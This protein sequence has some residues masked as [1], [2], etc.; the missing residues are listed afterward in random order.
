MRFNSVFHPACVNAA[1]NRLVSTFIMSPIASA[2]AVS[3]KWS[4]VSVDSQPSIITYAPLFA[5]I[6]IGLGIVVTLAIF[7]GKVIFRLGGLF[8]EVA[9]VSDKLKELRA[10][11]AKGNEELRYE[12]HN[13]TERV[14]EALVHHRHT[15]TDGGVI[16]TR[17][18]NS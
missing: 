6:V 5:S 12:I 9:T 17:P 8:T 4:S 2:H 1:V 11:V 14:V 13:S 16:F 3:W 10:D 18:I 15:D 7:G